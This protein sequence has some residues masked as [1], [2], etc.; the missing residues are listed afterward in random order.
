MYMEATLDPDHG[1]EIARN[2]AQIYSYAQRRMGQVDIKNDSAAALEVA[3]LLEPLRQAWID[4]AKEAHEAPAAAGSSQRA[5]G[6][7]GELE[8]LNL[9]T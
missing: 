8:S 6:S 4:L 5:D 1:G 9:S 3:D 7:R 2:L